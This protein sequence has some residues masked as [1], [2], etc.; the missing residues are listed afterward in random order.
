MYTEMYAHVY[1]GVLSYNE[2]CHRVITVVLY[3][4]AEPRV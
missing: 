1:M 4:C 2:L 3:R